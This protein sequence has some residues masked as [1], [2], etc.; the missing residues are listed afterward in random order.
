M[1][2]VIVTI[3][4]GALSSAGGTV[5]GASVVGASVVGASVVGCSVVGASV[6]GASVVGASV[7]GISVVVVSSFP[8]QDTSTDAS[9]SNTNKI[10]INFFILL[11]SLTN[12]LKI[13]LLSN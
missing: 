8:P 3:S 10:G 7:V 12:T 5:V 2:K 1:S 11:S 6:V 13:Q 4:F 9:M